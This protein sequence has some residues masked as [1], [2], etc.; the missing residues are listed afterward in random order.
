MD[1]IRSIVFFGDYFWEFYNDQTPKVKEKIELALYYLQYS[2]Q[3]PSK[4]VGATDHKNLFYLRIKQSSNIYRVFFCYDE[5]RLVVLFN[6]FQKKS[7]K[8]PRN[9][10][11]RALRIQKQYF[12]EKNK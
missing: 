2:K 5:G 7:M 8:I 10:I 9:H 4:F 3:L 6:G 11:D 12:D 1:K